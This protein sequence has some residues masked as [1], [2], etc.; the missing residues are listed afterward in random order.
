[1]EASKAVTRKAGVWRG[2]TAEERVAPR[3]EKLVRA[4]FELLGEHGQAGTTVRGVCARANLNA[5]YFY[6]SFDDLDALLCAVFD[7][8]LAETTALTLAAIVA[9]PDS[10]EAKTRAALE[11]SIRHIADDPR[12]IRIVFAEGSDGVLGRRRAAAVRRTAEMMADQAAAFFKVDRK[13]R[14]LISATL[15]IT[16]GLGEL[17]VAWSNGDVDLTVDE[18]IDHATLMTL[19]ASRAMGAL[20][21]QRRR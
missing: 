12:R 13:D 3:R 7:D 17:L 15:M 9:A 4:G 8:I 20:G 11:A 5:R 21:R 1:V 10:A 16:G 19:G 6:E 14:L 2:T 18:L